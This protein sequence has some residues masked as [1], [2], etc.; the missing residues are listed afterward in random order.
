MAGSS[1]ASC[2]A[3]CIGQAVLPQSTGNQSGQS[4]S[5]LLPH[6][7]RAAHSLG[8]CHACCCPVCQ[9]RLPARPMHAASLLWPTLV[10]VCGM[11]GDNTGTAPACQQVTAKRW[12]CLQKARA[13]HRDVRGPADQ[14]LPCTQRADALTR[15]AQPAADQRVC[16]QFSRCLPDVG[17][18]CRRTAAV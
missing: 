2:P 3:A 16:L 7:R 15:A 9:Q 11:P 12:P 6:D 4:V 5:Q 1:H 10:P 13:R 8:E 18:A 17:R 14:L